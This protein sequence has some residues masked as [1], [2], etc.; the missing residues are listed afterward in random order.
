MHTIFISTYVLSAQTCNPVV[1]KTPTNSWK[2]QLKLAR[3]HYY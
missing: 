2:L 3:N 1:Q